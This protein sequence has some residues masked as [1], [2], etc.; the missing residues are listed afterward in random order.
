M[1]DERGN[2][3]L[4]GVAHQLPHVMMGDVFDGGGRRGARAAPGISGGLVEDGAGVR[5]S[6]VGGNGWVGVG[7]MGPGAWG[8]ADA[9]KAVVGR[10]Q[11]P[12]NQFQLS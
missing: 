8:V 10:K 2:R 12:I 7:R 5:E 11:V 3:A 1:V 4:F 9:G 6:A